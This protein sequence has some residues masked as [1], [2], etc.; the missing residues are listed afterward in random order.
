MKATKEMVRE[1]AEKAISWVTEAWKDDKDG[2]YWLDAYHGCGVYQL[3]IKNGRIVGSI[4]DGF[5]GSR[6]YFR[7]YEE[8][9]RQEWIDALTEVISEKIGE[10]T[11]AKADGSGTYFYLREPMEGVQVKEYDVPSVHGGYHHNIEIR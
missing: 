2:R 10:F 8:V 11:F 1:S 5:Y 3:I 4:Y 6:P 9:T 7:D